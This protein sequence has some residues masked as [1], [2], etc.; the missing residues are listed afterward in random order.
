[1]RLFLRDLWTKVTE[2]LPFIAPL[3]VSLGLCTVALSRIAFLRPRAEKLAFQIHRSARSNFARSLVEPLVADAARSHRC[4]PRQHDHGLA[5]TRSRVMILKSFVSPREPGVLKI[6]FSE[7]I[8]RLPQIP[9]FAEL[10]GRYRLVLEPSWTGAADPGL[11]QYAA[12]PGP[13]VVLAGAKTDFDFLTRLSSALRPIRIGPCDW[14]DPRCAEPYLGSPKEFDLVL[15]STWVPW[16]RHRVLFR[17]LSRLD[18]KIR[19]ALIGVPWEGGTL[20]DIMASA[21]AFGVSEQLTVFEHIPFHRVMEIHAKS[22]TAA[23]LSL[24]EGSNRALAEAIFC[25]VPVIL[26]DRHWGGITKNDV[27]QTGIVTSERGL[28]HSITDLIERGA[29]LRPRS[30]AMEHISSTVST[31]KLTAFL[32]EIASERGEDWTHDLFVHSNSPECTY[33]NPEDG[34]ALADEYGALDAL[35]RR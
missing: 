32:Q 5:F 27:P 2:S 7:T 9:G 26:L 4:K 15:N 33:W 25:D 1:M 6:M 24:K 8:E 31:A 19:V 23:L 14:V 20:D 28:P 30:W 35:F 21:A 3:W 18:R 16:K 34:L 22:R 12:L 29:T 10:F 17:A 13:V 11:L